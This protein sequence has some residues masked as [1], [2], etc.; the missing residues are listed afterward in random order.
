MKV[1]P[2]V[3]EMCEQVLQCKRDGLTIGL[4]PT[5]GYFHAGHIALMKRA[6][7]LTDRVIVSL[8]VNPTQFGPNEDLSRYP[9]NMERDTLM[10]EEAGVDILFTPD[11]TELYPKDFSTWVHVEGVSEHLCGKSRPGH[12]RGVATIVAKLFGIVQPDKAVFGQKDFQQ[13][14]IIKRMVKDL[15]IPVE[16]IGHETVREPDG[17]AMSSRNTYLSQEE[18]S[19][20]TCLYHALCMVKNA[21]KRQDTTL[22]S[23][24]TAIFS[25]ISASPLVKIDYVFIGDPH[26]LQPYDADGFQKA[27]DVLVAMA[28]WVGKT[29]LIDNMCFTKEPQ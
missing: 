21:L 14:A 5:M 7:E 18:R 1:I 9:R 28:V 11:A 25:E 24:Q 27:K 13:L 29:R 10:A 4:V 20:A 8:F 17:L 19:L 22:S 26:S 3:S 6:K 23:L 15:N 16:I 12:F 2:S